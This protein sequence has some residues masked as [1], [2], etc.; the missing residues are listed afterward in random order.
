MA[1]FFP[2]PEGDAQC[3]ETLD[4]KESQPLSEM[5]LADFTLLTWTAPVGDY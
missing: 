2:K 4:S 1:G 3:L 5:M